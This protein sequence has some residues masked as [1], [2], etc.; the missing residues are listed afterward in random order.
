MESIVTLLL[1]NGLIIG[2]IYALISLGFNVIYRTTGVINFA[3]GEFVMIGGVV[4]G[5]AFTT[6]GWPLPVAIGVGILAA[7][8][9]GVLLDLCAIRLVR[10][11][12]PVIQIIITIGASIIIRS[13][14]ALVWGTE[15]F[16]L[17]VFKEGSLSLAGQHIDYHSLLIVAVAGVC[18]A[19]L[20]LFFRCTTVGM[21]MK[22]CAENAE[23]ARLC[24][25]R[26]G[27]ISTMA[28]GISGL[29][30]GIGGCLIT[31]LLSMGF[32]RGTMLG[33]K[34]FAAAILGGIGNPIGGVVGGLAMGLLEQGSTWFSSDYKD[35]LA[36]TIVVLVLLIRPR[37]LLSK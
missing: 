28:F 37:G 17:P 29:L 36:L 15:P 16:H 30:G 7:G 20:T 1:V 5:W 35:I 19:L 24:G 13:I 27:R 14:A 25:V 32:D 4:S 8:L 11:A 31:P 34:G 2:S 33:L 18:M 12:T 9:V 3:Q 6:L 23:A 21:A 10:G 22:A 26:T